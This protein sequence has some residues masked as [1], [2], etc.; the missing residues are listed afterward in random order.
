MGFGTRDAIAIAIVIVKV[1]KR[2]LRT[3]RIAKLTWIIH[4]KLN[5]FN[6]RS[7]IFNCNCE[8]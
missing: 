1:E 5:S 7:Q 6:V 4:F 8:I 2:S 3:R